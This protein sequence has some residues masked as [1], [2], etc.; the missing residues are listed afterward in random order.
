MRTGGLRRPQFTGCDPSTTE[1]GRRRCRSRSIC[2]GCPRSAGI[3][4]TRR[5]AT[6]G[7]RPPRNHKAHIINM[8]WNYCIGSPNRRASDATSA[9]PPDRIRSC[10]VVVRSR[11][12]VAHHLSRPVRRQPHQPARR[13]HVRLAIRS[14][15]L[16][17]ERPQVP[18]RAA[19]ARRDHELLLRHQSC[20][21]VSSPSASRRPRTA[22]TGPS[23][24]PATRVP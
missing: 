7:T 23:P 20:R 4:F 5:G 6:W 12:H 11:T 19:R 10:A 16:S 17:V 13:A 1:A 15:T 8:L 22:S 3:R 9:S 2:E 14:R 21:C 24:T 18:V